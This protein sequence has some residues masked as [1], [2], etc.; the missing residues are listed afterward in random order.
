M[1]NASVPF[2][3]CGRFKNCKAKH[4][5]LCVLTLSM[6]V[7]KGRYSLLCVYKIWQLT[8]I[9]NDSKVQIFL[10]VY[11]TKEIQYDFDVS[12]KK[13]FTRKLPYITL[14]LLLSLL[15][16]T[17]IQYFLQ[18]W[19]ESFWKFVCSVKQT[20]G[21]NLYYCYSQTCLGFSPI[22]A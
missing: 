6:A 4:H 1:S 15:M 11:V 13:N 2:L 20:A 18:Y 19:R 10:S 22:V 3:F 12:K 9:G 14:A 17:E 21:T 8:H 16:Q 5:F 7:L